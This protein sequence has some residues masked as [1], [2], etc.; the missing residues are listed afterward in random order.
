MFGNGFWEIWPFLLSFH[1]GL[2]STCLPRPGPELTGHTE[3][4]L[5]T[6]LW[7]QKWFSVRWTMPKR[8]GDRKER[9]EQLFSLF[10]LNGLFVSVVAFWRWLLDWTTSLFL[11]CCGHLVN[12]WTW[13]LCLLFLLYCLS[14]FSSH[15][16]TWHFTCPPPP[17]KCCMS[18]VPR[19]VIQ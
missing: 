1:P 7:A 5:V 11:W 16:C 17:I 4:G 14:S 10:L 13:T 9:A 2:T 19:T 6:E 8:T 3:R 15:L 18:F 12:A